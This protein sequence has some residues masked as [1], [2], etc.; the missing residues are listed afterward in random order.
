MYLTLGSTRRAYRE[1]LANGSWRQKENSSDPWR[2]DSECVENHFFKD[3]VRRKVSGWSFKLNSFYKI[4]TS[5]DVCFTVWNI[6]S[7]NGFLNVFLV[8][9]QEDEMLRQTAL[10]LISVIGYSLSLFSLVLATLLMGMLRSVLMKKTYDSYT[11]C[12]FI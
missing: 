10:R 7:N 11:K 6:S 5:S 2:G 8:C 3:K 4:Q 12:S 1:C 9:V